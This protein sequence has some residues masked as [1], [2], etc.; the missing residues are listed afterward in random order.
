VLGIHKSN[1]QKKVCR[2]FSLSEK[3]GKIERE[4]EEKKM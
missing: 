3:K 4:E 1:T 2:V